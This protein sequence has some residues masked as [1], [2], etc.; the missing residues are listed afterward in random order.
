M[1]RNNRYS[2]RS[3]KKSKPAQTGH[4]PQPDVKKGDGSVNNGV[5]VYSGAI[6]LDSLAKSLGLLPAVILKELFMAGKMITINSILDDELIAEICINHNFDFRKEEIVEKEDFEKTG[7]VIDEAKAA[8]RAPVVTIMGHVNHGKT[9]LIDAIRG[10]DIVSGEAGSITQSIG[11]YQKVVNGKKITFLDTPGHEAFTAMRARGASLTD[12]AVIVVAADDGV[13]PQTREAID[14]A[15]A[16]G[17]SIIIAVNKIDRPGANPEKVKSELSGLGLTPEEWGGNTIFVEI[18]AKQRMNLEKLLET[19]LFVAEVKELKADP[20]ARAYGTVIEATLDV[21]EGAKA[22]FLVQNGTLKI[23]D[24]LVVGNSYCKIRRMTNEHGKSVKEADPSTPVAVTG[25]SEVPTAGDHFIA[26]ESEKEAKQVAQKRT[27]TA[28]S[29]RNFSRPVLSLDNMFER[30]ESGQNPK[31]AVI[32]KADTQ[33]S[34]EAIKAS[35][36]KI[37]IEGVELAIIRGAAGEISEGD[38]I[39]AEASNAVLLGF[40]TKANSMAISKAKEEGVEMRFYT[41]IY[42]LLDDIQM[43]MKG[44]LKPVMHEVV[45]G[46]A[47]I[48]QLFKSSAAGIICGSMVTEGTIKN[49]AKVRLLRKNELISETTINSLKRFKDDVKEVSSGYDCGI[50]LEK[51]KDIMVDDVIECYGEEEIKNG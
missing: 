6:S 3:K 16:A 28:L 43:A 11:A 19:I 38:V 30:L 24:Q 35:L 18:S 29:R 7:L 22:T 45:F 32:I 4:A 50:V 13:M 8:E 10:S 33:G 20:T 47:V 49:R 21:H 44:K 15:L 14:H 37:K 2:S 5:F 25:L 41:V 26:F 40:N 1:G 42:R 17:V 34:V 9:T 39:L 31:V 27:L 12:I 23:G 48:T 51:V 36:D 46:R